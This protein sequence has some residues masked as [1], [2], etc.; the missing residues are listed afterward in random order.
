MSE[1]I[2]KRYK[3]RAKKALGQNF[4]VNEDII[5][6][7]ADVIETED[8]NIIEVW[9]WYWALTQKLLERNLESLTLVELD[10]DMVKI[11]EDRIKLWELESENTNFE[12]KNIDVLRFIPEWD[13]RY[14]V[15][16]NIPYY[17]TSPILRHFLYELDNKPDEM[18]ILM[19]KDV[20]DKIL[21]IFKS[22][23]PKSSVI[24]LMMAKKCIVTEELLVSPDN[25]V[26]APNVQSSVLKFVKHSNFWETDDE[27]FL[28]FIK[29]WFSSARKKLIK[30]LV[31][32]G[33]DKQKVL[34]VFEKLQISEG[35]RWEGIWIEKW[36][37]LV[38]ELI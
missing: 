8:K 32:W 12:I 7:I 31:N 30:N 25:F 18:V 35:V 24:W 33:F 20:W 3:I 21:D 15:I 14:S 29:I 26:P 9:P 11:L 28:R 38:D 1:E 16:A 2:L 17:I 23:K 4:L 6:S 19:Q 27:K 13:Y 10:S 37:K 34:E 5:E 36:C 22:K